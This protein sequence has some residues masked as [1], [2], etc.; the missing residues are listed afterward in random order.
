MGGRRGILCLAALLLLFGREASAR[1]EVDLL[2]V[3]AVDASGS[4]SEERFALQRQ[5]YAYAFRSPRL[6]NAIRSGATQSIAVMMF[7]WTGPGMQVQAAQWTRLADEASARAFAATVEQAPRQ[8]FGGGTSISGAIDHGM[9]MME[10]APFSAPRRVIDVSGDGS[11]NRG[12]PV[13][14]ARDA[15]VAAGVV[16]NGLPILAMELG[17]EDFYRDH[18][19]GGPGAFMIP[20]ASFEEFGPAVLRKLVAEIAGIAPAP[21]VGTGMPPVQSFNEARNPPIASATSAGVCTAMKWPLSSAWNRAPGMAC[22]IGSTS[23]GGRSRSWMP[24]SSSVGQ[25]IAPYEDERSVS[26]SMR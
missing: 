21:H 24:A 11:N 2:L 12:R 8:L 3:L 20:V 26:T 13:A 7:Q 19:I 16:V 17:L 25:A 9:R 22:A 1:T 5:G 18:V 4:I 15:A 14:D 10:Q 6:A 23:A